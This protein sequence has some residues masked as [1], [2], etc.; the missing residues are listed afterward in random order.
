[1]MLLIKKLSEPRIFLSFGVIY[2]LFV[3]FI[4]LLPA[5]EIPNISISFGDK[6]AHFLIHGVLS[7]IW[8]CYAF[9]SNKGRISVKYVVLVLVIC[10]SYGLLIEVSQKLFLPSRTYDLFDIVANC[11]G[12]IFGLLVYLVV[13]RKYGEFFLNIRA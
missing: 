8:L 5:S 4:F 9:L 2:T 3:T 10:L 13:R 7:F 12:S 6:V 11:I 1:M